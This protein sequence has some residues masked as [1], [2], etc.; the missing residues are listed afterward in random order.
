MSG[1]PHR[2]PEN[3]GPPSG[4]MAGLP[5]PPPRQ[6]KLAIHDRRRP[7]QAEKT[8]PSVRMTRA[9]RGNYPPAEPGGEAI[10]T[11]AGG[12]RFA[13]H[14]GVSS[15]ASQ[16]RPLDGLF[17]CEARAMSDDDV[18]AES[19]PASI[20]SEYCAATLADTA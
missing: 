17:C 7:R 2:R 20:A 13:S 15:I 6:S 19:A 10:E 3:P 8:I 18:R 5:Q 4:R 12:P 9:T 14:C 16:R 11:L 1:S